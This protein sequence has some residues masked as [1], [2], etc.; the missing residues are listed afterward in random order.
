M[1]EP[2]K[3]HMAAAKKMVKKIKATMNSN[4]DAKVI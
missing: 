1:E 3:S 2:R 4:A